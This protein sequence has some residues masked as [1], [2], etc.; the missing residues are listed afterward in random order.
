MGQEFTTNMDGKLTYDFRCL[1]CNKEQ[2]VF[3]SS[4]DIP[5][6]GVI[7]LDKDA[8]QKKIDEERFCECGGKLKRVYSTKPLDSVWVSDSGYVQNGS[9]HRILQKGGTSGFHSKLRS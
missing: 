7:I 4:T 2:E 5:H 6:K 8:L 1:E 9:T 3:I